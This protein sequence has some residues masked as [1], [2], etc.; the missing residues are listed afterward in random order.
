MAL[1]WGK[2]VSRPTVRKV[3]EKDTLNTQYKAQKH[4]QIRLIWKNIFAY[5]LHIMM[6]PKFL[7]VSSHCRMT[8]RDCIKTLKE[9]E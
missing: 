8:L 3:P 5:L 9:N 6:C 2:T 7:H 1:Y 4:C